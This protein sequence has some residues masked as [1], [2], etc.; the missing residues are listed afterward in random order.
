MNFWQKMV[1]C[2]LC[3]TEMVNW[4]LLISNW[5]GLKPILLR[6]FRVNDKWKSRQKVPVAQIDCQLGR[7]QK[8]WENIQQKV[9]RQI[10]IYSL[11][12][13]LKLGCLLNRKCKKKQR[14]WKVKSR[15][16][17]DS[18]RLFRI[19]LINYT[20]LFNIPFAIGGFLC[21]IMLLF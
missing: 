20:L 13:K 1:M 3:H 16:F 17:F 19:S 9:N 5:A 11:L 4:S 10:K 12:S 2:S 7:G 8:R 15:S 14:L 18:H 6:N 21:Q